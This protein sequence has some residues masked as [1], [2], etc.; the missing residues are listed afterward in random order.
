MHSLYSLYT[1]GTKCDT[2][3]TQK[4]ISKVYCKEKIFT[5]IENPLLCGTNVA[6][7][8]IS[9]EA[10]FQVGHFQVGSNIIPPTKVGGFYP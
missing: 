7:K 4:F 1:R 3:V 10:H 5:V 2:N 9:K 8:F 6:Q